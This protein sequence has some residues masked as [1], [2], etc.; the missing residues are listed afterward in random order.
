MMG[1][2]KEGEKERRRDGGG[3]GGGGED[4]KWSCPQVWVRNTYNSGP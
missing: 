4:E 1:E 3:G 2:K